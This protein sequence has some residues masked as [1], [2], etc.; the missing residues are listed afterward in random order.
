MTTQAGGIRIDGPAPEISPGALSKLAGDTFALTFGH[1][2]AREDLDAF[3]RD[4]HSPA[5]YAE[6]LA[7]A[8]YGVFIAFQEETPVGYLVAGPCDLP[9]EDMPARSGEL[10]RFYI[11]PD[12]Q[13]AGIG[14]AMLN[15]GLDWLN[16]RFDHLYL[17]VY[18]DNEGAQRLYARYGFEKVQEYFYMVGSQADPEYI[19]KQTR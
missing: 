7:D 6:L 4:K 13:G 17:S 12:W 5:V 14:K 9:V 19:L 10:M 15:A 2:Y 16:E 3:L 11:M 1:L 18:R 8:E